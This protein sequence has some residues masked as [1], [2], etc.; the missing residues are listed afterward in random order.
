MSILW[1][2]P[3]MSYIGDLVETKLELQETRLDLAEWFLT[4]KLYDILTVELGY[5]WQ[6]TSFY[7]Y[8]E[9]G[10]HLRLE[11]EPIE[12]D[13]DATEDLFILDGINFPVFVLEGPEEEI[14]R[15]VRLAAKQQLEWLM[16]AA[17][18]KMLRY[19]DKLK[20]F[21]DEID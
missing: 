3:D 7:A 2:E 21:D 14:R 1:L 11:F 20:D 9:G 8:N 15:Y 16:G 5:N 4:S 13:N 6:V 18:H 12:D 17:R 10:L 19:A